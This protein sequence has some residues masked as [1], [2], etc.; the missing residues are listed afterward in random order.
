M[1]ICLQ[2]SPFIFKLIYEMRFD[3]ARAPRI[4]LFGH[5]Y[6]GLRLMAQDL[7]KLLSGELS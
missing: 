3:Q 4:A 5:F 6:I 7:G 1:S 2:T